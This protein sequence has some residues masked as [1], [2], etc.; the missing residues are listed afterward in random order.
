VAV[1]LVALLSL[2]PKRVELE[3]FIGRCLFEGGIWESPRTSDGINGIERVLERGPDVL[4]AHGKIWEIDQSIHA[5]WL[6]IE[7]AGTSD[8]FVWRLYY[9]VIASSER[10]ARDAPSNHDR[11]EDIEWRARLEGDATV[12]DSVLAIVPG[13]TEVSVRELPAREPS[14]PRRSRRPRT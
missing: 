6:E 11:P 1:D 3:W 2:D 12:Q 10:R 7:R 4:R 8:R 5:F 14:E 9:D 13:S